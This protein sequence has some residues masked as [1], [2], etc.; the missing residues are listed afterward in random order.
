MRVPRSNCTSTFIGNFLDNFKLELQFFAAADRAEVELPK[1]SRESKL[2]PALI[3][4]N[5]QLQTNRAPNVRERNVSAN[6]L[7]PDV[8]VE[9]KQLPILDKAVERIAVEVIA[10]GGIGWPIRIRVVRRKNQDAAAGPCNA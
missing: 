7:E 4:I 8:G 5:D 9:R 2:R 10:V 3:E 6:W 1:L